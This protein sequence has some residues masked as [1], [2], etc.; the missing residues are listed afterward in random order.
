MKFSSN[1]M[2][3]RGGLQTPHK[4]IPYYVLTFNLLTERYGSD[5]QE[6]TKTHRKIRQEVKS[7][8]G[9]EIREVILFGSL[10]RGE[11]TAKSDIDLLVITSSDWY[12]M[13]KRLSE[14]IV[15]FLLETGEYISAKAVNV[16]EYE[17]MKRLRAGFYENIEREG[18]VIG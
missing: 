9:G 11:A 10:A 16:E 7:R 3:P 6:Q 5:N 4:K 1:L 8:Y 18:V 2:I 14:V 15:E 12:D 17:F 13:Q